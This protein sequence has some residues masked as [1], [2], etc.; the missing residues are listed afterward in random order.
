MFRFGVGKHKLLKCLAESESEH[1]ESQY[2]IAPDTV[3]YLEGFVRTNGKCCLFTSQFRLICLER[4]VKRDGFL[5]YTDI[6]STV[7]SRE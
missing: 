1:N 2:K 6:K 3:L 5:M 7:Y 4:P